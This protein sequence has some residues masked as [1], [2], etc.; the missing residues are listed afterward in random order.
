MALSVKIP[1][2]LEKEC[3]KGIPYNSGLAELK[4]S[5]FKS[6]YV[7][8]NLTSKLSSDSVKGV[9]FSNSLLH[10]CGINSKA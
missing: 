4:N 2:N 7:G 3:T 10:F 9:L 8:F 1:S 5:L 6:L